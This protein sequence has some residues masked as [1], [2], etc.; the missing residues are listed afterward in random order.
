MS[1]YLVTMPR[2]GESV[3]EGSIVRWFVGPGDHVDEFDPLVEISSDKV[4]SEIPAPVTG[5]VVEIVAEE[6]A[7]IPVGGNI[8]VIELDVHRDGAE[9]SEQ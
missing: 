1:L 3:T 5:T 6:G 8:A 4:E 2:L 9:A 7:D